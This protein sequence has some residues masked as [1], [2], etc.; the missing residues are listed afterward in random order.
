MTDPV[1]PGSPARIVEDNLRYAV[2]HAAAL[3]GAES[4]EAA[5]AALGD[6]R[7]E[8]AHPALPPVGVRTTRDLVV[9]DSDTAAALGHPD[10]GMAVLGSPRLGLWFELVCCDLLP[11][12][13]NG[14]T[15]V[16]AGILVH[17][18]GRSDAGETVTVEATVAHTSGRHVL[19]DC[20]ARTGDR[21]VGSGTHH[22]VL[23]DRS[24]SG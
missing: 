23:L 21:V 7:A 10:D 4:L 16:G 5:A 24:A 3:T 9:K 15:S 18:L 17:H 13:G 14:P 19:F 22:R 2:R 11:R 6:S 1:L 12:P 20:L 8:E